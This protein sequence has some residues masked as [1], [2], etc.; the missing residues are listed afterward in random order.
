MPR[1]S[2]AAAG[3]ARSAVRMN[4]ALISFNWIMPGHPEAAPHSHA[5]DQLAL[6]LAVRSSSTSA[7]A[8]GRRARAAL[9][10]R[11]GAARRTRRRR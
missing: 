7:G 6:I 4:G 8:T 11:G 10:S 5:Y 1:E 3:L 2:I 9:H